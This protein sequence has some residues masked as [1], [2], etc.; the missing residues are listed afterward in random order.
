[1]RDPRASVRLGAVGRGKSQGLPI[2]RGREGK[3]EGCCVGARPGTPSLSRQRC[4]G[5]VPVAPR[6]VPGGRPAS[7]STR[8]DV[9]GVSCGPT[10]HQGK[11]F[12]LPN[13]FSSAPGW[14]RGRS[15]ALGGL[16]PFLTPHCPSLRVVLR[17][18]ALG[19]VVTR[20]WL[21][22]VLQKNPHAPHGL[23]GPRGLA[24]DQN[25]VR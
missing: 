19:A 21:G 8:T 5:C 12:C 17:L 9:A 13:T 3:R 2:E 23:P 4:F 24:G 10:Q 18:G 7:S 16:T 6:P 22:A 20:W 1:M 14:A 25:A 15:A 11:L